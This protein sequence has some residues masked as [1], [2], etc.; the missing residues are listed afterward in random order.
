VGHRLPMDTTDCEPTNRGGGGSGGV[1]GDV[2]TG[3][4]RGHVLGVLIAAL[5]GAEL[6]KDIFLSVD[7]GEWLPA[8]EF[9]YYGIIACLPFL[10]AK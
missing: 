9:V 7:R 6:V 2:Q 1:H 5:I 4:N 8:Y 3:M 10:L